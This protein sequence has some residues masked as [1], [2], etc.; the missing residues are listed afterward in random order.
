MSSMADG[1][2]DFV[3]IANRLPVDRVTV[4]D[5][6]DDVAQLPRRTGHRARARHE[7][8]RRRLDRLA[9]SRRREGQ[10]LR[11]Q[12]HAAGARPAVRGRG[13][14][15]LR[16]LLERDAVAAVPRRRRAAGVPPRVVGLLRAG[17]PALR[18]EG[19][20]GRQPGRRRLGAGLPAPAGPDD[21]A[22]RCDPTCA[23]AS[24]C[25]SRSLPPSC[26]SSCR[27]AARSSRACSA[28]IWSAS[29]CPAPRRTSS[30]W[31]AS[32]SVTRPTAT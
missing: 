22:R 31:C 28:P 13:R 15:V 24:S 9:R 1:T 7:A 23:S 10:A 25:T 19:R 18:R 6:Q 14:G 21:A 26:S 30:A 29:R 12:R 16:G 5:R 20:R 17:Q 4:P 3:V 27:G 32:A 8:Q 2:A 11:A